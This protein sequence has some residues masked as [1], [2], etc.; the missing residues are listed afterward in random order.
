MND[1]FQDP[2]R[3]SEFLAC[4]IL[5][6]CQESEARAFLRDNYLE[7]CD[8]QPQLRIP[9]EGQVIFISAPDFEYAFGS[10]CLWR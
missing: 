6:L 7:V 3:T 10:R 4:C 5:G 9:L 8:V 1:Q 2:A